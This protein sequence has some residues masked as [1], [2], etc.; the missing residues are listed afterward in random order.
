MFKET[1]PL[2]YLHRNAQLTRFKSNNISKYSEISAILSLYHFL[3]SEVGKI[4]SVRVF[5]AVIVFTNKYLPQA[6]YYKVLYSELPRERKV[7]SFI[8]LLSKAFGQK[9]SCYLLLCLS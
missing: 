1:F 8:L 2:E 7:S 3:E 9:S 5:Y 6:C 4:N